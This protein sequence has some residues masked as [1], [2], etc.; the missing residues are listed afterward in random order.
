MRAG[1]GRAL[2]DAEREEGLLDPTLADLLRGLVA[3]V[4][5]AQLLDLLDQLPRS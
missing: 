5:V 4:P 2:D 3:R 1:L